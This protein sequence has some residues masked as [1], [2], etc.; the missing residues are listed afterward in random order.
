[1]N[2]GCDTYAARWFCKEDWWLTRLITIR[3]NAGHLIE[4][5]LAHK[6][7]YGNTLLLEP[8]EKYVALIRSVFGPEEHQRHGYPGHPEIELALLRLYA[9]TGNQDAYE[10]A[11]YFIEE[12]GNPRGQNGVL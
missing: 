3:Y 11:R 7:Y 10:L 5:A 2:C 6:K 9:A 8:I 1:M 4:A 12:R